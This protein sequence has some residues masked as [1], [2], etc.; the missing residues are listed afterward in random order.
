MRAAA[1]NSL[2]FPLCIPPLQRTREQQD[3]H[4]GPPLISIPLL[5]WHLH[6]CNV[7]SDNE[8]SGC[9]VLACWLLPLWS[10]LSC[11]AR[12]IHTTTKRLISCGSFCFVWFLCLSKKVQDAAGPNRITG[13]TSTFQTCFKLFRFSKA[14]PDDSLM[15]QS[16]YYFHHYFLSVLLSD[17]WELS[18]GRGGGQ[19]AV[20]AWLRHPQLLPALLPAGQ[21]G[22][23]G[24]CLTG[25]LCAVNKKKVL[26]V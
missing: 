12:H 16:Y 4:L 5:H 23:G 11:V 9:V 14:T 13:T 20:P 15:F 3:Q 26:C 21:V 1:I 22:D 7:G 6:H 8:F 10:A 18:H 17:Q 24:G 19:R 25:N 2:V